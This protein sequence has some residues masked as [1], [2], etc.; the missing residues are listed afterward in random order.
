MSNSSTY[1]YSISWLHKVSILAPRLFS[2]SH[3][4][5]ACPE[6]ICLCCFHS[7]PYFMYWTEAY[8]EYPMLPGV[9]NTPKPTC[10]KNVLRSFNIEIDAVLYPQLDACTTVIAGL[11]CLNLTVANR[12]ECESFSQNTVPRDTNTSR[13]TNSTRDVIKKRKSWLWAH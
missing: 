12:G 10:S 13:K 4:E 9:V 6:R 1:R 7:S 5:H 11:S 3:S 8:R 2:S